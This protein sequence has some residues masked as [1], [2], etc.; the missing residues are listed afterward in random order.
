MI[1]GGLAGTGAQAREQGEVFKHFHGRR[2]I[3][4]ANK[5]AQARRAQV[6]R[7][8]T[9][10]PSRR[11]LKPLLGGTLGII[12]NYL[13]L[14]LIFEAVV[15]IQKPTAALTMASAAANR[16]IETPKRAKTRT[17]M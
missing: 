14:L 8:G 1:A 11:C 7:H 6:V 17:R 5:K 4:M 3:Q 10:T 16:A 2:V 12:L 15:N 13:G 9:E